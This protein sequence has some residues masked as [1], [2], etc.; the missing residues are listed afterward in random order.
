LDDFN[1]K[2]QLFFGEPSVYGAF[3]NNQLLA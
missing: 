3:K 1:D 2:Y